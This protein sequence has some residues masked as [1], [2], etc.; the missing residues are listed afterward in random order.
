M[1][2][3]PFAVIALMAVAVVAQR[4]PAAPAAK[5]GDAAKFEDVTAAAGITFQHERAA[6]H[7]RLAKIMP[8]LTAGGSGVAIGDYDK[9]GLDDIYFTTSA[10]G[11]PNHLYHN[12][13]HF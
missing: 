13:G 4:T 1:I 2:A 3:K 8:W 7:P 12:E 10:L 5:P 9:D 11:K 6:F